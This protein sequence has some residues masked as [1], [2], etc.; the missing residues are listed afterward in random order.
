MESQTLC[1]ILGGVEV[2]WLSSREGLVLVSQKSTFVQ[3]L[4][5][6][7]ISLQEYSP[8]GISGRSSSLELALFLVCSLTFPLDWFEKVSQVPSFSTFLPIPEVQPGKALFSFGCRSTID[9]F[10]WKWNGEEWC[11]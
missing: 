7:V 6:S 11:P 4:T 5:S 8:R 10:R 9:E 3:L 2:S 1:Y